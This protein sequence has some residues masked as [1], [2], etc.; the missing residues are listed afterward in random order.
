MKFLQEVE[1]SNKH[2]PE[3]SQET[4]IENYRYKSVGETNEGDLDDRILPMNDREKMVRRWVLDNFKAIK[5][6]KLE[7]DFDCPQQNSL[8]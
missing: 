8:S 7:E 4:D 2:Y 6:Y 5:E 1:L 3:D